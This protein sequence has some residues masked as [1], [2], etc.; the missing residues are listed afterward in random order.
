MT[1][2]KQ[3]FGTGMGIGM[4]TPMERDEGPL[5]DALPYRQGVF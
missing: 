2:S 5:P 1:L 4:Q 3:E